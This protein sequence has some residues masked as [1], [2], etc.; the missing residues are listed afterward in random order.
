MGYCNKCIFTIFYL[1]IVLSSVIGNH[2]RIRDYYTMDR[3]TPQLDS[4]WGGEDSILFA[5]GWESGSET[6][7]IFRKAI[8]AKEPLDHNLSGVLHLIWSRGQAFSS[9]TDPIYN[10]FYAQDEIKYHGYGP[11]QRGVRTILFSGRLKQEV[12]TVS[13]IFIHIFQKLF[14]FFY[15]FTQ[16][17][18]SLR[19][20]NIAINQKICT[21]FSKYNIRKLLKNSQTLKIR[22]FIAFIG[23]STL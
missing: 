23:D 20:I 14:I 12:E 21:F 15:I 17:E 18:I 16:N 11:N 7:V 22:R 1:D 13:H 2:S 10:R 6:T 19:F 4:F 5:T 9:N 8:S 3:S